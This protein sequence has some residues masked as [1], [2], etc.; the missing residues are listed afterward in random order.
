MK[1][2]LSTILLTGLFA[3][4]LGA[5]G[6]G[7]TSTSTNNVTSTG[8]NTP[9]STPVSSEITSTVEQSPI[10]SLEAVSATA[11][12]KIGEQAT[13]ANFYELKG[14]KSLSAKQKRVT[15]TSSDENVVK[16]AASYKT[17]TAVNL[18]TATITVTSDVD[19]TKTCS[20]TVTV[21]DAF[22]DRTITSISSTWDVT[23]E[24][25]EENPYIKIDSN[26]ADG[27]YARNSDGLKWYIETEITIH[28]INAGEEWPKFGIVANTTTHTEN[29]N[30]KLYYFLN[31]PMNVEGN[32]K[33]FGVCEVSNGA[34]WAWNAGVGNNEARHNDVVTSVDTTI[35]YETKFHMGMVRDGFNC[36]LYA[37][38]AYIGS[39]EVL[40]TLFGNY[41][42]DTQAYTD[43]A[44]A[45]AGFFS[46]NSVITFSNYKFVSE[47]AEV[48]ALIPAEP[49]FNTG[50]AQD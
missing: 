40:G 5:C 25:A 24:M 47:A 14:V 37:N 8:G 42:A 1:K 38:H 50:W 11:E 43:P 17:M 10:K 2:K 44:P 45:M 7:N 23:N 9:T 46:F 49:A 18:G 28:S 15:I 33:D 21:T 36:H 31:A 27:I 29:N 41:S 48:D 39:I 19:T 34:N 26:L 22:F 12:I 13:T 6:G 35:T 4:S 3:V 20:F 16:I 32:W 30:N